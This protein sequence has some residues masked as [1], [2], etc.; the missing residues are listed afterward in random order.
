MQQLLEQQFLDW[1]RGRLELVS[2][3]SGQGGI[4]QLLK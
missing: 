1:D 2:K 4:L 3:G